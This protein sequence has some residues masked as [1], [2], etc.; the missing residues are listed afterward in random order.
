[1]TFSNTRVFVT[2]ITG[3]VGGTFLNLWLADPSTLKNYS[4]RALVRSAT[5]AEQDIRPLGVEPVIGSLDDLDLITHESAAADV[6]LNFADADHLPSIKAILEGLS[7]P[8]TSPARARPIL[9]HTSGTGVICDSAYG[10][11]ASKDIYHDNNITQL[12]ALAVTQPHRRIDLE[13]LSPSLVGHV[14][15]YIVAPPMIFGFGTGPGN[16]TSIQ[17]PMQVRHS[18]RNKQ[19]LQT[20]DGLNIWSKVHVVDLARFY[21]L[22]LERSLKEPQTKEAAQLAV[23]GFGNTL[24]TLPKNQDGYWF[25]EDGEFAWGSVAQSIAEALAKEG[26]NTTGTVRATAP[27]DEEAVWGK[28]VF[29]GAYIGANSRSRAVKAGEFLGWLPEAGRD[30]NTYIA[31]EVKRQ[32]DEGKH[33]G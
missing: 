16:Q 25:V 24:A 19:A 14:D 10:A 18:L 1:M 30:L 15:T 12:G 26:I 9:I 21:I 20:G 23:D 29:P 6:V 31:K 28:N 13:V 11:Y 32:L 5:K 8:R 22:L 4:I 27:E 3:Y 17:I 7:E 2:G 33:H